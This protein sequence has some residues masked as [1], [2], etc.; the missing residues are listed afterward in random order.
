MSRSIRQRAY[1][2]IRRRAMTGSLA[3]GTRLSIRQVA[4]Q[5]EVSAIPVREALTQL[6]SEGLLEHKPGV[7][8][9]VVE[10]APDELAELC[11][12]REALECHAI[13]KMAPLADST[14]VEQL[15]RYKTAM[16]GVIEQIQ[17]ASGENWNTPQMDAW[18]LADAQFHMAILKA[19]GNRR[20]LK[21]VSDLRVLTYSLGHRD[22]RRTVERLQRA[23]A[24]HGEILDAIAAHDAPA[25]EQAMAHHLAQGS[26]ATMEALQRQRME[27]RDALLPEALQS[28]LH[29]LEE[30]AS[31]APP[32]L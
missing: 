1:D 3:P 17:R 2:Y 31:D 23:D 9:F 18:T 30:S 15:Q 6:V 13:R 19:A 29:A 27:I 14:L 12:L 22:R 8:I 5:L 28:Q 26:R 24:E 10:L 20:T 32:E 25:A 7:G 4:R 16:E 11:D 21:I